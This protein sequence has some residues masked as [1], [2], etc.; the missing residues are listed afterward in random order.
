MASGEELNEFNLSEK[1]AFELLRDALG[2]AFL[3]GDSG[4]RHYDPKNGLLEEEERESFRHV[5]L[6]G[7]LARS[8][9]RLNPWISDYNVSVV[10]RRL[11]GVQAS[12]LIEANQEV[13]YQLG[14]LAVEQDLGVGKKSQTV[15]V[16]DFKNPENNE[17][18][19][20]RQ[21][22]V[23]GQKKDIKPDLTVF[24]N[25]LPVAVIECKS[26]T[27]SGEPLDEGMTQL[28]RYQDASTG[29]PQLFHYAQFLVSTCGQAAESATV[30]SARKYFVPWRDP[31]PRSV[32][33]LG[34]R[35][36]REPN[37]QEVLLFGI[38]SKAN[39]LDLI[40]NFVVFEAENGRLVKKVARYQQF[41]AVNKALERVKS[42]GA[43]PDKGGIIWHWQGSGKSLTMLWLALK[44]RREPSLN[45]PALVVITDRIQLNRQI[46]A[47]FERCGF[48]VPVSARDAEDLREQLRTGAGKTVF[49]TVQKF[50]TKEGEAAGRFEVLSDS[51]DVFVL[52]DEAHRTQYGELAAN[53][54]QA[55][56][57]ACYFGFTGTP[58]EK[59]DRSTRRTFGPAIDAYDIWQSNQDKATVPIYYESR[60]AQLQVKG[61]SI[62]AMLKQMFPE[63]SEDECAKLKK[64]YANE[65]AIAGAPER[66]KRICLDI[67]AHYSNAIAPNGFKAQIVANDRRAAL[68]YKLA[69]DE[70]GAVK[71]ALVVSPSEFPGDPEATALL[72]DCLRKQ[73]A[74]L[75]D[76]NA[77]DAKF[78]LPLNE[79]D[80]CVM[81][82]NE[83]RLTGFDAP[84]EQVMYFDSN[85][86]GHDL[87]QA[88]ARVD[89]PYEKKN[90]GLVVDYYGVSGFLSEALGIFRQADVEFALKPVSDA[91]PLLQMRHRT[92]LAFFSGVSLDDIEACVSVLESEDTRVRFEK[93]FK[94]FAES[95]DMVMPSPEANPYREN[96][97][98]LGAVL[99]AARQ[100]F[101]D[102]GLS[103][104]AYGNKV[105]KL[106]EEH[107]Q[108]TGV[109]S[110]GE[111]G[112]ITDP[113]FKE[114]VAD[115][116]S[117]EAKA[118]EMEHAI[119]Y[120]LR[121]RR[122]ENPVYF[123]SL[124]D[125]L[126]RLIAEKQAKRIELV[127]FLDAMNQLKEDVV[128]VSQ[129]AK[130][131][132]LDNP[133]QFGVF[134]LLQKEG[135]NPTASKKV[136]VI[137]FKRL[138]DV[139][140][141]DWASKDS[142]QREARR[143]IKRILREDG[144][145]EE[146]IEATTA[147]VVDLARIH[148]RR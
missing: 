41:R 6:A 117:D 44:L 95:M 83:M 74:E 90:Y 17:F 126:K 139:L 52:V 48:P 50:L 134:E 81:I 106:V 76:Y 34:E 102:E 138:E 8:I 73:E 56:P 22:K 86:K 18:L 7:R 69:L 131:A 96:L 75:G 132:G 40:Q 88:V 148:M 57:N 99:N 10:A 137:A 42:G 45:N 36:G 58:I 11:S 105:R 80:L 63:L 29:A 93:A 15:K 109:S 120:E 55:L 51:R 67:V 27:L 71:S 114:R 128:S 1:P 30:G 39:L 78:K 113:A 54:R 133:F 65:T 103:L 12:G 13:Y 84:V 118:S 72:N 97:K 145:P 136:A 89:R 125:K 79:S 64:K 5:V 24:V 141:V 43:P 9:R 107:I 19:V 28:E 115:L 25:G 32:H 37:P 77:V 47:T 147:Q 129:K 66:I 142:V 70:I 110:L 143:A 68:R 98:R 61:G 101:R 82:V 33:E 119:W 116:P 16:I 108:A 2:Y 62:D 91:I 140:V 14:N 38:F 87:L 104:K 23:W 122:D 85:R 31:Y 4:E 121:V 46:S 53:M 21:F 127:A 124:E 111:F 35:F 146:R 92:A 60:L 130:E 123:E 20:V 100:R 135:L 144:F 26:P 112:S 59:D 3:E 94:E 49:S